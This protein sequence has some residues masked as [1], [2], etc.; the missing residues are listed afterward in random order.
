MSISSL[1][2]GMTASPSPA[3]APAT[4]PSVTPHPVMPQALPIDASKSILAAIDEAV[5]LVDHDLI[6]RFMNP[7]AETMLE[8]VF[9]A[10]D[11]GIL[12]N[13][14]CGKNIFQDQ[15]VAI[16]DGFLR[17]VF[18]SG[19]HFN[20]DIHA[21]A[22]FISRSQ[23]K[24]PIELS[25]VP[26]SQNGKINYVVVTIR[27]IIQARQQQ[28]LIEQRLK[29][30]TTIVQEEQARLKASINSLNLG[31]IMTDQ[32]GQ[33]IVINDVAKLLICATSTDQPYGAY[34]NANFKNQACSLDDI[35]TQLQQFFDLKSAINQCFTQ[36]KPIDIKE[37]QFHNMMLHIQIRPIINLT[38]KIEVL[39]TVVVIE[40]VTRERALERSKDEF[41]SIASH[42]L[43]T[44]LT[45]IRGNTMLIKEYF[46]DKI[47]DKDLQ[48]M[49]SDIHDSSTRLIEIVNDFLDTSRLEQSRMKFNL[50]VFDLKSLAQQVVNELGS[51]A[52]EKNVALGLENVQGEYPPVHADKDRVKQVVINLIGNALKFTTAGGVYLSFAVEGEMLRLRVRDTGR[53]ISP[54]N[55]ALL[56]KKF[57]Q[58]QDNILTRDSTRGTGLG[59]YISKLLIEKMGGEIGLELSEE[60]KGSVFSFTLPITK[61]SVTPAL[62]KA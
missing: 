57:Q 3:P 37:V 2:K 52:K 34:D 16:G 30:Q 55:Q 49:I 9:D 38:E 13:E 32:T 40:D 5:L 10:D 12:W 45:A 33:A 39:G 54:A 35:Q 21:N 31:F 36:E 62:P 24:I 44:P 4:Q 43:R 48:E 18:H 25:T 47:Q 51:I 11:G 29:N 42:E 59:L 26:I 50:E 7:V 8:R 60:G 61:N 14:L 1:L 19:Q 15:Y 56:F 28:D 46:F 27:N 58:A 17:E 6:V 20:L 22:H 53:G 23:K 41:F